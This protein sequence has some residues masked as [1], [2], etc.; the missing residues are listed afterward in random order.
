MG[1]DVLNVG[2]S[3]L[4]A[5]KKSLSTTSHNIA[6][7]N[8]EGYSRQRVNLE[9]SNPISEGSHVLGTGVDVKSVKRIHDQQIERRVNQATTVN[10]YNQERFFQLSQV[11]E[12]FNEIN[13]DG[14]NKVLNRFFN[15]FRELA[16]QPENETVR[17]IVR[18]NARIVVRDFKGMRNTIHD[19]RDN[20]NNK[21]RATV[22]D[23][24]T[25]LHH[26]RN[27]NN[28]IAQMEALAEETGDL[29][30][31]RDKIVKN[32][33]ELMDIDTFEDEKGRYVINVRDVG[34][35][36][37]GG[38]INEL[39]F[40]SIN[41]DNKDVG[42]FEIFYKDGG[43]GPVSPKIKGGKIGAMLETREKELVKVSDRLDRIA[44]E[45][46]NTV[47]AIHRRGFVNAKIP[48]D[49]NGNPQGRYLAS[50]KP[51][52][53]IN[54]FKEPED[55]YRASE[56]L[57]LSDEVK[58]DLNNIST[59]LEPN[60][61]GDNRIAIAISKL[62]HE[63]VLLEGTTTFEEH[64]LEAVGD[65]GLSASKSKIDSEQSRGILAQARSIK[66]R[67]SGVSIDEETANM[68]KFQH[69]YDASAKVIKTADEMFKSLLDMK[70]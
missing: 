48:V 32:L 56:Y 5:A 42:K 1:V 46:A 28:K 54:F 18:E 70:R 31:Q 69:A 26:A 33:S 27:L 41:K 65:I 3:G 20:I 37:V 13:S 66:E 6:N 63:K 49:Q 39:K 36:V 2:R 58:E 35:L 40:G 10:E 67:V 60:R 19:I 30:D 43:T 4:A 24:N 51:F 68:V 17:S 57:D 21:I 22:D 25:M 23:I 34:S 12:I 55:L 44:F 9:A 8:T 64:Y 50:G 38:E 11:E 15:S 61:S 7:A 62:Q 16:N 53:G 52:T 45:L 59:G 14:M 29:R 47:N